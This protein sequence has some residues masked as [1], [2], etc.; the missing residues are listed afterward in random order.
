MMAP[1]TRLSWMHIRSAA[2]VSRRPASGDLQIL[3]KLRHR[4]NDRS[5]Q[6]HRRHAEGIRHFS[7]GSASSARDP[8]RTLRISLNSREAGRSARR[9]AGIQCHLVK[10]AKQCWTDGKSRFQARSVSD[11]IAKLHQIEAN[12][13]DFVSDRLGSIRSNEHNQ[14]GRVASARPESPGNPR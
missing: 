9:G 12:R 3:D 4:P 13:P 11:P 7:W 8:C 6:I 10:R 5:R 14:C 2:Q 1:Q